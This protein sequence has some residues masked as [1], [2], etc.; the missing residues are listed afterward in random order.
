MLPNI[1]IKGFGDPFLISEE[2][3]I[4]VRELK[5]LGC[6]RINDI[7]LD[8]TAFNIE[9]LA[10]GAGLSD[11]PYDAQNNALAVNF[12]TVNIVKDKTGDVHS[13]EE[14]TPT[15]PLMVELA[16]NLEPG[17]H[18]INISRNKTISN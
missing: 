1:Y 11:N 6:R 5:R 13:A 15:L 12:N 7:Y 17:T 18:R 14:Q 3:A 8:D 10:D 9:T 2:V 4:I 16:E